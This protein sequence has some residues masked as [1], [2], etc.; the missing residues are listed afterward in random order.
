MRIANFLFLFFILN[1]QLNG[2]C[3]SSAIDAKFIN[4]KANLGDSIVVTVT[5]KTDVI[6]NNDGTSFSLFV[7]HLLI[8]CCVTALTGQSVKIKAT[9]I[10]NEVITVAT[11]GDCQPS[12]W[13]KEI[14][15]IAN[16]MPVTWLSCPTATIKK[17]QSIISWSVASQTNN[18]HFIIEH[19]SDGR[20]Y[21][22]I[23]KVQGHGTTSEIKHYN[24]IHEAPSS[25]INYYRIKQVDYDGQSSYS[26]VVT[27][28]YESDGGD[29]RIYPNPASNKV[30]ITI[31]G[32]TEL[33]V[34]DILGKVLHKSKW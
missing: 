11:S 21:S 5:E 20:S 13:S 10:G 34:R 29:I 24:C 30:T 3:I 18:S 33:V 12:F 19:S 2:Q 25:G 9:A 14:E 15:V 1:I 4:A 32:P 28:V 7:D 23:G 16:S 8:N 22:E 17:N 26:D 6:L 27:V 31:S